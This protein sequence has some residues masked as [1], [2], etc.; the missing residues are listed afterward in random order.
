MAPFVDLIGPAEDSYMP[1]GPPMSPLT[2]S[3]FHYWAHFDARAGR[4]GETIGTTVLALGADLGI[5]GEMLRL[6][7]A[8]QRSRMGVFIQEGKAGRDGGQPVVDF[9]DVWSGEPSRA[10]VPAGHG[11]APGELWYA[12]ILSAPGGEGAVP[13]VITTPYML[14][15]PGADQWRACIRR[16]LPGAP[17]SAASP[18]Y[19]EYMKFGPT[20]SYWSDF[21][22]EAYADHRREAIFLDGLPDDPGSRP[23][24]AANDWGSG[25]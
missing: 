10:V 22:F 3:F 11:G 12:R 24:S 21:V 13:V 15:R 19:E 5:P 7:E 25:R 20:P 6:F 18:G 9:R 23:C 16:A 1:Q 8:M 2:Q 4:A 14:R 17:E